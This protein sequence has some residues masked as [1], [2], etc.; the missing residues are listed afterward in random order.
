M[1]NLFARLSK[2]DR[3]P[4]IIKD[5]N[6]EELKDFLELLDAF[7]HVAEQDDQV[8]SPSV[9]MTSS[10]SPSPRTPRMSMDAL[11]QLGFDDLLHPEDVGQPLP[12]ARYSQERVVTPRRL[13]LDEEGTTPPTKKHKSIGAEAMYG[14]DKGGS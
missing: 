4:H 12:P 8:L 7:K 11:S 13:K 9:S 6:G 10:V 1:F 5:M 3:Y 2:R 14:K